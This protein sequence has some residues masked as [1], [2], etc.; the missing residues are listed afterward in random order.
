[1]RV[2]PVEVRRLKRWLIPASALSLATLA[3]GV[4]VLAELGLGRAPRASGPSAGAPRRVGSP[5]QG[6]LRPYAGGGPTPIAPL[7]A[8]ARRMTPALGTINA[9]A[10]QR[11]H[12]DPALAALHAERSLEARM[13]RLDELLAGLDADAAV[14]LLTRLLDARLPG[15]VYEERTLRLTVLARIGALPGAQSAAILLRSTESNRPRPER[16]IAIEFLSGRG[17]AARTRLE[18]LASDDPDEVVQKK[19]RWALARAK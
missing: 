12:S 8:V 1:M 16:L 10:P 9:Q 6:R 2:A 17:G 18:A 14:G 3:V 5:T 7:P 19:A 13:Q 11:P 15:S 4:L